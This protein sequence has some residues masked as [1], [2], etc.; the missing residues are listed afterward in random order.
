MMNNYGAYCGSFVIRIVRDLSFG[1]FGYKAGDIQVLHE[2]QL[3][4]ARVGADLEFGGETIRGSDYRLIAD[5][6]S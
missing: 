5:F 1:R 4:A 2:R 3:P 6:P